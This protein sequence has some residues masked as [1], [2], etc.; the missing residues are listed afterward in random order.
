MVLTIFQGKLSQRGMSNEKHK[1]KMVTETPL[2][3][4][5]KA[6]QALMQTFR[7]RNCHQSMN[8]IIIRVY[9]CMECIES[10][11]LLVKRIL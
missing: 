6:C 11:K 8:S 5:E 1:R 7:Q 10:I 3:M 9:F 4:A 2:L